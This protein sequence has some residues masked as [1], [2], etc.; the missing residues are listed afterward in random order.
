VLCDR[1]ARLRD[2]LFSRIPSLI[3]TPSPLL[4]SCSLLSQVHDVRFSNKK[5]CAGGASMESEAYFREKAAQCR[6]MAYGILNSRDPMVQAL[7]TLAQEFEAKATLYLANS[8][9]GS[10]SSD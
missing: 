6:R 1:E 7:L 3:L 9:D 2:R 4:M 8:P 5:T 10:S